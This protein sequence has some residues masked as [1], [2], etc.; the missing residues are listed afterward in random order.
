MRQGKRTAVSDI[1]EILPFILFLLVCCSVAF[2]IRRDASKE[3]YLQEYFATNYKSGRVGRI[4]GFIM[5]AYTF[6]V[7]AF[8]KSPIMTTNTSSTQSVYTLLT[9]FAIAFVAGL[10]TC[11]I[12][13][14]KLKRASNKTLFSTIV[15]A[16]QAR[17]DSTVVTIAAGL[18]IVVLCGAALVIVSFF[19]GQLA[20][21]TLKISEGAAFLLL[22]IPATIVVI[23]GGRKGIA[24]INTLSL[25]LT[26]LGIVAFVALLQAPHDDLMLQDGKLVQ[27]SYLISAEIDQLLGGVSYYALH[28]PLFASTCTLLFSAN[29]VLT[30]NLILGHC[31]AHRIPTSKLQKRLLVGASAVVIACVC[32]ILGCL[33]GTISNFII[34]LM[35]NF[36]VVLFFP[37]VWSVVVGFIWR[38]A[39][40]QGV[41]LSFIVGL[42]VSGICIVLATLEISC[43]AGAIASLIALIVG[44][45]AAKKELSAES[46]VLFFERKQ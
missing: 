45:L 20:H 11:L 30:H 43:A 17:Y 3:L 40:T 5:M 14:V 13:S 42:L 1:F 37:C 38:G 33:P 46:E 10:V 19:A 32:L 34:A 16:L 18:C 35:L 7:L 15:D 6:F 2:A 29:A 24:T 27:A 12:A 23:T 36:M 8:L 21:L 25:V 28:A 26:I 39:N 44:S 9:L 4:A 22:L 31:E 41:V